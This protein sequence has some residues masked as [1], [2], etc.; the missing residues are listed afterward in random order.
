MDIR[1]LNADD[2]DIA[3]QAVELFKNKKPA[4]GEIARFLKSDSHYM[5]LAIENDNPI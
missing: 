3:C 4:V 1:R 5:I 2:A